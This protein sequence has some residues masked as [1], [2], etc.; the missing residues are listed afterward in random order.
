M[1]SSIV[2]FADEVLQLLEPAAQQASQILTV[3]GR[4]EA[5]SQ[6][7]ININL[8][9]L[10]DSHSQA[11]DWLKSQIESN[12]SL[13]AK[14]KD[15]ISLNHEHTMKRFDAVDKRNNEQ[16]RARI[17]S[18]LSPI[19]YSQ[20]HKR[21]YGEVLEGTGEWLL[22]DDQYADWRD[23]NPSAMLWLHGIPGSG[24]SRLVYVVRCRH[25]F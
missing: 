19:P 25:R 4:I 16:D 20:H 12:N 13:M 17:L 21:V 11:R 7:A 15:S 5:R 8:L 18:W 10:S 23:S 9:S 2:R 1:L 24:K 3:C 6:A 14:L 22:E